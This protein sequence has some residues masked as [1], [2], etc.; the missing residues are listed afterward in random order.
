MNHIK[1]V[2]LGFLVIPFLLNSLAIAH[3]RIYTP[4]GVSIEDIKKRVT[5]TNS[6]IVVDFEGVIFEHSLY[7]RLVEAVKNTTKS[8]FAKSKEVVAKAKDSVAVLLQKNEVKSA[9]VAEQVEI[10]SSKSKKI[11]YGMGIFLSKLVLERGYSVIAAINLMYEYEQYKNNQNA[12]VADKRVFECISGVCLLNDFVAHSFAISEDETQIVVFISD[13]GDLVRQ[14]AM[15]GV[16]G[17]HFVNVGQLCSDLSEL[18][19][20]VMSRARYGL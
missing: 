7:D 5:P 13:N 14:A 1:K 2:F 15:Q 16:I 18:G 19:F 6:C 17:V 8:G 9:E 12:S 4:E 11:R 3:P 10:P 20:P